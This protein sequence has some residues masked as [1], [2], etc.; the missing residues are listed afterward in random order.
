[1]S[2]ITDS[3]HQAYLFMFFSAVL[4]K[5][6]SPFYAEGERKIFSL[7]ACLP[8]SVCPHQQ[9]CQREQMLYFNNPGISEG[10]R[11]I[12]LSL[13]RIPG[14]ILLLIRPELMF[15]ELGSVPFNR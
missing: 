4:I 15:S 5:E 1:M 3:N 8:A 2:H 10:F 9:S 13:I 11:G 14:N 12:N 7:A 6:D